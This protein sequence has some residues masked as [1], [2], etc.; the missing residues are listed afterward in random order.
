MSWAPQPPAQKTPICTLY[1]FHDHLVPLSLCHFP[2]LTPLIWY[3]NSN[4]SHFHSRSTSLN[5]KTARNVTLKLLHSTTAAQP[6]KNG[7]LSGVMVFL[8]RTLQN[9]ANEGCHFLRQGPLH[10]QNLR[11][12]KWD[13]RYR[14]LN[15]PKSSFDYSCQSSFCR[16]CWECRHPPPKRRHCNS[17]SSQVFYYLIFFI[18]V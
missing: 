4:A 17:R 11:R 10:G 2:F 12:R 7:S 13:L 3:T 5:T 18:L 14:F 8:Q 16:C 15:P 9:W 6:S 1:W